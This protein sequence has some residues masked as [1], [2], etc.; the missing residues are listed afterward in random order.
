MGL[1]SGAGGDDRLQVELAVFAIVI[2]LTVTLLIPMVAPAYAQT[3]YSYENIYLEKASLEAYTGESMTNMTPWA[4]TGVYTAWSVNE[5]VNI[6]PET[7]WL[8]GQKIDSYSRTGFEGTTS[9][10]AHSTSPIYLDPGQKSNRPLAQTQETVAIEGNEWWSVGLNGE[11]NLFGHIAEYFGINHTT[12]VQEDINNWSFTGY[13]YEF[14]PMLYLDYT[15][16][17]STRYSEPSQTDAKLS[18]VWYSGGSGEGLSSGLVLYNNKNSGMLANITFGEIR[19]KYDQAV[20][21]ATKFELAYDTVKVYINIKFDQDVIAGSV[22]LTQAWTEGRW[23]MAVTAASMDAFM[24]LNGSN[25]LSSSAANILDTYISIFT[26]SLPQTPLVWS[27][28]LWIVCIL[29]VDLAIL[30]F[31]SRFGIVGVGMGILGNVL[32]G[33]MGA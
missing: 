33:V 4:L 3:G 16:P 30:M 7:G 15:D 23:S 12:T 10:A 27:M 25:T 18:I 20:N 17:N 2:S 1:F 9:V 8:Y 32:L 24:N 5:P 14:D 19:E 6:D 13:R 31:L 22:D 21:H 26:F 11:L 29:P 28:V